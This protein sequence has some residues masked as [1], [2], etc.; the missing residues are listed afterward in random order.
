MRSPEQ[1]IKRPLLTEKGT[2][3]KET[4]GSGDGEARS[5]DA[6][7]AAAVR[8]R[9]RRQQD[10]DPPRGRE[11]LERRRRRR[12]HRD[13]A[14]QGEAD[15]PLRRQPLEL[16]EGHRDHR[17]GP[18]HRVLRR[19]LRVTMG[20]RPHNATTPGSRGRVAPDFAELSQGNEPEKSLTEQMS[21]TGGRND[22]GR[23][24]SR[25]RGG[26]HKRRFRVDRLPPQQGRRAG[27]GRHASSTIRTA[28]RASR[29]CTTPTA[30]SATSSAPTGSR[31]ATRC[32]RRATPTSSRATTC[33][34]ASSRSA[35][36]STTSSSRSRAARRCAARP[37]SARR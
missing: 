17:A 36:R 37:A 2:L 32:C 9:A 35:R 16:E 25:F 12:P 13:R 34:C 10:R 5:R 19:S 21:R 29:S 6:E 33:R 30:R 3:L 26:G 24:T 1:I 4:G 14:R 18:E 7:V 15:G 8:G 22:Y 20:L 11:A 31:S 23:I 27:Q 28:P